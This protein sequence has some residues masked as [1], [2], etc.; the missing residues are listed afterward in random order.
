GKRLREQRA[1]LDLDL[2]LVV[3]ELVERFRGPRRGFGEV[4]VLRV[5]A[6]PAE[7][8]EDLAVAVDE[9]LEC[10]GI[11]LH[12]LSLYVRRIAAV[13]AAMPSAV[14]SGMDTRRIA[15]EPPSSPR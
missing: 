14:A 1:H 5:V 4:L 13:E 3:D 15:W 12:G 2:L 9:E 8:L 6:E 11:E 7:A 10:L